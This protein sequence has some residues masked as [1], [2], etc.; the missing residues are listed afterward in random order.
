MTGMPRSLASVRP[1]KSTADTLDRYCNVAL[2]PQVND[3]ITRYNTTLKKFVDAQDD[4]WEAIVAT[5]R[6][7]LQKAF[8]EHLQVGDNSQRAGLGVTGRCQGEHLRLPWTLA[9]QSVCIV[10]NE[11]P[12]CAC[13]R[14]LCFWLCVVTYACRDLWPCPAAVCTVPGDCCQG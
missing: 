12:S 9:S 4:E 6:G 10:G 5:Y 8:F 7:D 13:Y 2:R 3:E 14:S 11:L 1:L